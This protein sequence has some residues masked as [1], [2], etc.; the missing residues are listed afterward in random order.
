MCSGNGGS[1]KDHLIRVSYCN[2]LKKHETINR[3]LL[4]VP[5]R[6]PVWDLRFLT[7]SFCF[8][9]LFPIEIYLNYESFL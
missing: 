7:F 6:Q 4:K 3:H 1:E 9:Y 8:I 5:L 2:L